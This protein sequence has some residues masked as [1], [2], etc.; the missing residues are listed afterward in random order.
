MLR[1]LLI[2]FLFITSYNPLFSQIEKGKF[3]IGITSTVSNTGLTQLGFQSEKRKGDGFESESEKTFSVNL[4][5]KFGMFFWDNLTVG[6]EG[7]LS[8]LSVKKDSFSGDDIN[9]SIFMGGPFAR[10]YYGHKNV[11][12]FAEV[13][14]LLGRSKFKFDDPNPDGFDSTINSNISSFGGGIGLAAQLGNKI[15]FDTVLVYNSF[16]DKNTDDNPANERTITSGV[17]LKVGFSLYLN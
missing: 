9:G 1:F 11:R 17:Q 15:S 2:V 4:S 8:I 3:L 7:H 16:T 5:P 13:S 10:Y 14:A 12:P 6:V